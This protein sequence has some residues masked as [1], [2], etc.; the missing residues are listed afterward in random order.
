[1]IISVALQE[2]VARA[3]HLICTCELGSALWEAPGCPGR[4]EK[5]GAHRKKWS[6]RIIFKLLARRQSNFC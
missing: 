6:G 5:T 1:M 4:N 2:C 3:R